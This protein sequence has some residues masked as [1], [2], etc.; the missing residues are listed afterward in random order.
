MNRRV[1]HLLYVAAGTNC[2]GSHLGTLPATTE[3]LHG[4][5]SASVII[6]SVR[7]LTGTH[8]VECVGRAIVATPDVFCS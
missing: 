4:L 2:A 7:Q 8:T 6:A 1:L 5:K 3:P